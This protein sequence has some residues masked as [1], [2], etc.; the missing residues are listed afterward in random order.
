MTLRG[1]GI[2]LQVLTE[3]ICYLLFGYLLFQLTFSGGYLNYVT[4][5]MKPYLYGMSALMLLWAVFTGRY[6]LTPRYRVRLARSFVFIIPILLLAFRPAD[7]GGSSMVRSYESSGFS[8]GFGNGGTDAY[9]EDDTGQSSGEENPWYDLNGLDEAEKT[10]TIADE[11]YYTWMYELSNFYEKYEGYTVVMKGFVFRTPDIQKKC[12]F[13]LVRLS[14]WCCAADLTPIG[15]LV[16]SDSEVTFKDDDWV[17]VTGTFGISE[18]EE[19]LILKAQSI[20]A[21][22]KPEEEYVYPYF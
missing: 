18:H 14:M 17:T 12:D 3:C 20:E 4:P 2:N 15:F 19:S 22:G 8:M 11:D 6:L 5:R 10:I 16:D 21:A 7:P 9:P 1:K 13:A